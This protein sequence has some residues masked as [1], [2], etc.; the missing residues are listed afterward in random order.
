MK[1]TITK[2]W[3]KDENNIKFP[4]EW[5]YVFVPAWEDAI[6]VMLLSKDWQLSKF[7][8]NWSNDEDWWTTRSV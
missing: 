7:I 6:A 2:Q 3:V 1:Y 4:R 8:I 5:K